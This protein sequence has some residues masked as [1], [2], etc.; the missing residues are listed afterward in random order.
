MA[1][2]LVVEKH[3]DRR[4][5]MIRA[6]Q[7][8]GHAV[9]AAGS[10]DAALVLMSHGHYDMLLTNQILAADESVEL[11]K[12]ALEQDPT[13]HVLLTTGAGA[14]ANAVLS[15]LPPAVRVHPT[16]FDLGELVS[17]VESTLAA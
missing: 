12:R 10:T 2:I 3:Q 7:H 16:P 6:L 9:A 1:H 5:F 17:Q 4:Y 13:I 14:R 15:E 8:A 11:A